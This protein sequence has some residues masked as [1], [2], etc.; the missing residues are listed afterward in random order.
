MST[1]YSDYDLFA[2]VYNAHWGAFATGCY[3]ILKHLALQHL[4][5]PSAVLDLCCGAGQLASRLSRDGYVVTGVDVSPSMVEIARGNASD[6][7]FHVQDARDGLPGRGYAAVLSTFD[8]LNHL[9]A[10]DDLGRVFRNVRDVLAAGGY[11]VFDL[12]MEAAYEARWHGTFGYV[13][14]DHVCMVRSSHDIA[15]RIGRMEVTIFEAAGS[16]WRRADVSLV[17]RWYAEADVRA[18]LRR[19]GFAEVDSHAAE[20]PI[21][22]GCPTFAGRMFFV[23]R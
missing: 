1:G 3:P 19:A 10:L 22:Q 8:S 13:E 6:A 11:F 7:A 4:P 15:E 17:Q 12:N 5:N 14:D 2:R 16:A 21:A 9:M 18:A 20:E 23:A